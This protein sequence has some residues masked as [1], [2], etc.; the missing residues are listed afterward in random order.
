VAPRQA[1]HILGAIT[2]P[3]LRGELSKSFLHEGIYTLYDVDA[4]LWWQS[5][6]SR[7]PTFAP[8]DA[9]PYLAADKQIISGPTESEEAK[10]A[11]IRGWLNEAVLSGLPA[12]WLLALQAYCAPTY[13]RVRIVTKRS[14][15]YTLEAN[16]VPRLLELEGHTPLPR[17]PYELGSQWPIGAVASPIER[18]RTSGLYSRYKAPVANFDWDSISNPERAA[19]WWD[20]V[21]FI[22]G[23]YEAQGAYEDESFLFDDANESTGLD[24]PYG[25]FTAMWYLSEKRRSAKSVMRAIVWTPNESDFNPLA[26]NPDPGL[27]D[28]RWGW[29]GYDDGGVLRPT[30]K[31][32]VRVIDEYPR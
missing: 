2:P 11:R 19:C 24:E 32:D 25:T 7:W 29:S 4:E 31:P 30:R 14:T 10:R 26:S 17:C 1:R 21:G 20:C 16:A 13:P 5:L 23:H 27:P 3:W 8:A 28:G 9:L 6:I 15:W 12:G 22:Y 18:L